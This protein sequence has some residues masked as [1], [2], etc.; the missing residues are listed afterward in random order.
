MTI[1]VVFDTN[2]FNKTMNNIVGYHQGFL[3]GAKSGH[4]ALL[5][6]MGNS[7]KE[8]LGN[9]VDSNARTSPQMLHHVYEWHRTGSPE[10]RLFDLSYS[11]SGG[12]LTVKYTLRQSTVIKNGSTVPFYNKAKI[13][14][15]GSPVTIAPVT[16][17]ALKF[18][19]GGEDV[20]VRGPVTV[21]N[22]GGTA[23][24]GAME[25]AFDS[26]FQNYFTQSFLRTS[27]ILFEMQRL[28]EYRQGLPKA[29]SGGRTAGIQAGKNWVAG[30][31]ALDVSFI[32]P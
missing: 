27:G 29:R 24:T 17:T 13:M 32:S 5:R 31:G 30:K 23:T 12:T 19:A 2:S 20:F 6:R 21:Q 10:A 26:F 9:F 4:T 11:T 3:E 18:Q 1:K 14:E 28:R 25:R 22:P 15:S 16:R 8:H 7:V